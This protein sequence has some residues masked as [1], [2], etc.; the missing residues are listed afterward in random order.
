[1]I[2]SV[3]LEHAQKRKGNKYNTYYFNWGHLINCMDSIE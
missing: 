3:S 2:F 1:M